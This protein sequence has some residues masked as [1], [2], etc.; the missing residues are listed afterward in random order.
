MTNTWPILY[1]KIWYIVWQLRSTSTI[2]FLICILIWPFATSCSSTPLYFLLTKVLHTTGDLLF[3]P[4]S[5]VGTLN[6]FASNCFEMWLVH[7]CFDSQLP[8]CFLY[9]DFTRSLFLPMV[10]SHLDSCKIFIPVGRL[11]LV[12]VRGAFTFLCIVSPLLFD[13][14]CFN[15]ML[16]LT[17]DQGSLSY[18]IWAWLDRV[19]ESMLAFLLNLL[20]VLFFR[21]VSSQLC[22]FIPVCLF[23]FFHFYFG[24]S[25]I[26]CYTSCAM[27]FIIDF[28][29]Y[30]WVYSF[31]SLL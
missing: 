11:V 30:T 3:A 19:L 1:V 26:W 18:R 2:F 29:H 14:V 4:L 13:S 12:V 25:D 10:F 8:L 15:L 9:I 27:S 20:F 17:I 5:I 7:S 23:C 31:I 21:W 6:D 16:T 24:H 28:S 22:P